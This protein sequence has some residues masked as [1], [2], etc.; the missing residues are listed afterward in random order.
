MATTFNLTSIFTTIATTTAKTIN[1]TINT[2]TA[3]PKHVCE[4]YTQKCTNHSALGTLWL[5]ILP[6]EDLWRQWIRGIV[7]FL[8]LVWF[9]IGVAIA[10][11]IFMNSIEYIISKSKTVTCTF[12]KI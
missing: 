9:F 11:D 5:P 1:D 10:S 2:T 3:N 12:K 8:A 4:D 7:Y 6:G